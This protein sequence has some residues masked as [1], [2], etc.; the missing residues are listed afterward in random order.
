MDYSSKRK[1][2]QNIS[3][4]N[5]LQSKFSVIDDE[6]CCNYYDHEFEMFK[7]EE[8]EYLMEYMDNMLRSEENGF[9]YPD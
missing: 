9:F 5:N 4:Y 3:N 1:A 7:K 6:D 8:R 2:S